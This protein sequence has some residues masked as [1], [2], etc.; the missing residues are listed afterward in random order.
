MAKH[1]LGKGLSALFS[2]YDDPASTS[3]T[4]PT[5]AKKPINNVASVEEPQ[6]NASSVKQENEFEEKMEKAIAQERRAVPTTQPTKTSKVQEPEDVD[7]I[8]EKAKSLLDD[9]KIPGAIRIDS[10]MP[11]IENM[12]Y[13]AEKENLE[14]KLSQIDQEMSYRETPRGVVDVPISLIDINLD[15]PR[16]NFSKEAMLELSESIKQ[17]GVIQPI[18]VVERNNRYMIVAGERR[19]R[20]S[21]MVGLKV[22]PCIIKNYTNREIKQISL[23]E[24]LQRED[25]NP[26]EVAYAIKQLIEDFGF[27][28]DQVAERLGVSR[29]LVT[30][31]L[32]ILNLEPEVIAM[33]EKGT[34]LTAHAKVLGGVKNREDQIKFAKKACNDKMSLR[35]FE[36]MIQEYLNPDKFKKK[37]MQLT[38]ELQHFVSRMQS[39]FKTKVGMFGTDRRGRIYIDYYTRDDL[40]RIS[41]LMQKLGY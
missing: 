35:E 32:R 30:N 13:T 34:L 4:A 14:R 17:H 19:Y 16:K 1:G 25:L 38:S 5:P 6:F 12:N 41:D 3:R 2:L 40:D 18:V 23:I 37:H 33:V 10:D 28:Q 21:K 7:A 15:Q 27:T 22:I 11:P 31:T 24:N 29:P 39:T 36:R 26:V 20:A 9:M 8:L